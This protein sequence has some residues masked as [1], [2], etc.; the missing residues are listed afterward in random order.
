M[1]Y[2]LARLAEEVAGRVVGD[3][4]REVSGIRSLGE[5]G[6]G[7]LSFLT[8]ARYRSEAAASGA[9]VLLV[10]TGTEGFDRDLLVVDDPY[11]ALSRLLELFHPAESREPGIDAT[12]IVAEKAE[13]DPSASVGPF[14]VIGSGARIGARAAVHAHVVVGR[15]CVVG[16]DAILHPR[17]VLYDRSVVGER[18]ILH[19]GVVLGS[20][21]FGYAFH[22]GAH[23]KLRHV[24]RAIVEP[25]VEIGANTTV[26]RALLEETRIGAG[27]KIDNLVQVA[28][29]V[30]LGPGCILVSQAGIAGSTTLGAGV[31]MAGQSGLAGHLEL[32]DGV[33]VS[34]KTAVF[35]SVPAGRRVAGIPA[36]DAGAWRRQQAL[37]RRLSELRNRVRKLEAL[38]GEIEMRDTDLKG[39]GA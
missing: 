19:A 33:Q 34:A 36:V 32:G 38:V 13:V 6:S 14:S 10:K 27:S 30:K 3:P 8:N 11:W 28:H 20:D 5:A 4:E 16:E 2:R 26:D 31:I 12:A 9:G 29:N 37:L 23:Q 17:V 35:K 18:C 15:D 39:D 25:D 1:S 22:D 21:G 7:H 24:G